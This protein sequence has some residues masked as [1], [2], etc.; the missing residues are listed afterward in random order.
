MTADGSESKGDHVASV[1]VL[2]P[3]EINPEMQNLAREL[4]ERYAT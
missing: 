4:S 2:V 1:L 3:K